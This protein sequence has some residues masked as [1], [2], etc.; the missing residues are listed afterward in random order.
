MKIS[1]KL[2][3]GF[4]VVIAVAVAMAAV[5]VLNLMSINEND[6]LMYEK[7]T[8]PIAQF[9]GVATSFQR[10]RVE[11]RDMIM[12]NDAA[13]IAEQEEAV[14]TR[15]SEINENADA[16]KIAILEQDEQQAY[17]DFMSARSVF[18]GFMDQIIQLARENKDEEAHAL[19]KSDAC[20]KAEMAEQDA[21]LKLVEIKREDAAVQS[22][23]NKSLANSAIMAVGIALLIGLILA[24]LIAMYISRMISGSLKKIAF[25][26]E[27]IA[28]GNLTVDIG[29][30]SKDEIGTLASS[31]HRMSENLNEVLGGIFAAS[32]QVSS[33]AKQLAD[34]SMS[35]SQGASEQASSIEELTASLEE[36]ASQTKLNAQN[37]SQ[38]NKLASI[39]QGNAEQGNG[40]MQEMLRAMEDINQSS[41][42][43]SKIIK[44]IDDIAFQTNILALNAAVEAARAGQHGKGFAVVAEEV[45]NLAA[46]SASAAKET[47]EMIEGSIRK[48]E[49]G[50][51][52]AVHTAE[53]LN[54]IVSGVAEA[55][56]LVKQIDV[57]SSEQAT[58]LAQINQAVMQVSQVVQANSAVSE[59]SAA[60]SKELSGQADMM[61]QSVGKFR[62]KRTVDASI[63]PAAPAAEA[64]P[65]VVAMKPRRVE[66]RPV[67]AAGKP[68][69]ALSDEEFGKY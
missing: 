66:A 36:I 16:Y 32:E 49:A 69:I 26:A 20:F 11:L 40:Q 64:A 21:I 30:D 15:R 19:L 43:I 28:D 6:L 8:V 33:G 52:L 59:Q 65:N 1:K 2:L 57:A 38:A 29:I 34:S 25:A 4:A 13:K 39:A 9:S 18:V 50:T 60:A 48:V 58:G 68:A 31:C 22:E 35:L 51:K 14:A 67:R 46:K 63:R 37:A 54:Q 44:V 45:R 42:S 5:G 3:L 47:T 17:D 55:A 56:A 62:L 41:A 24:I 12:E 10:V 61:R 23:E 53:A 27:G 7:M